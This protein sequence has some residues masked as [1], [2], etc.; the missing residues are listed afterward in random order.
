MSYFL[1]QA[2]WNTTGNVLLCGVAIT[3]LVAG[4]IKSDRPV[5]LSHYHTKTGVF[6]CW[7]EL[8]EMFI[9]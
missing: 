8:I 9:T 6:Y 2:R 3:L 4:K 7:S 1:C 5:G